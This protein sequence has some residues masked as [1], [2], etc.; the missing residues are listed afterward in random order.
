MVWRSDVGIQGRGGREGQ[1]EGW[2]G[3]GGRNI[4]VTLPNKMDG[5]EGTTNQIDQTGFFMCHIPAATIIIC[6]KLSSALASA[7]V[8]EYAE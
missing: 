4:P 3:G 8:S 1:G 2:G 5:G 6:M 7:A